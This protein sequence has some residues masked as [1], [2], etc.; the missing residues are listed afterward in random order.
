MKDGKSSGSSGREQG[1]FR[2]AQTVI[3]ESNEKLLINIHE[4]SALTGISVGT[5]YHWSSQ[6]RIPRVP[7]SARCLRFSLSEIRK[8]IAELN[9]LALNESQERKARK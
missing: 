2:A 7:L 5:L 1:G 3:T 8:W 9:E 4:L 6:G